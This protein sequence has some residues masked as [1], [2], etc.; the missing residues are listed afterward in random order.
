MGKKSRLNWNIPLCL[1]S[2]KCLYCKK[3]GCDVTDNEK[4][5]GIREKNINK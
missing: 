4:Q 2:C 1:K 3:R 5:E